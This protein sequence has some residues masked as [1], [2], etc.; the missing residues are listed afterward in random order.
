M[1]T[2]GMTIELEDS[3]TAM[4]QQA[5][6]IAMV[7]TWIA[8]GAFALIAWTAGSRGHEHRVV[9]LRA[10]VETNSSEPMVAN[11]L[12]ATCVMATLTAVLGAI[13]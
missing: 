1:V 3:V 10:M 11:S 7:V 4:A 5:R 6:N 2:S 8:L 13:T 12:S 9:R